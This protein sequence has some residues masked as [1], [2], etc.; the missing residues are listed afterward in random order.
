MEWATEA[1]VDGDEA[2]VAV[3]LNGDRLELRLDE[4]L[5]VVAAER[6]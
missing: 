2:V 3:G 4:S 1:E 6:T 5:S